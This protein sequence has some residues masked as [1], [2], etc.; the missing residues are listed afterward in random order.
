MRN[1]VWIA[2]ILILFSANVLAISGTLINNLRLQRIDAITDKYESDRV[3][4]EDANKR[5]LMTHLYTIDAF[6]D[7]AEDIFDNDKFP[8]GVTALISFDGD[9][10]GKINEKYGTGGGDRLSFAFSEVV[11][12]HFPDS[13][14][15]IVTNVGEKSDEFYMLLL[16]RESEDAVE[17]EIK[18]FQEDIRKV[19]V[20][21]DDQVTDVKGT[22]SVG[23]AFYNG[24]DSF[25]SL[26]DAADSAAY[27][28]KEAGKDCYRIAK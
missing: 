2:I 24:K 27:E 22:V 10:M 9:G 6:M 11:R 16:V 15:N 20:K 21:A 13:E 23:I 17:Q 18:S 5:T 26:F 4:I 8:P 14:Y 19:T 28:A 1:K 7:I 12:K 3:A 25:V